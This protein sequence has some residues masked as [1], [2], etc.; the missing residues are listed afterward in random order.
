MQISST[1]AAGSGAAPRSP[2]QVLGKDQFLQLL[3]MQLQNQDPLQPVQDEQFLAQMAQFSA[4][5]QMNNIS[6]LTALHAGVQL[7]GHRV[8]AVDP[9]SGAPLTAIVTGVRSHGGQVLLR[10]GDQIEVPVDAV[11][12][13]SEK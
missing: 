2:S 5:E 9:G 4:L 7:L 1:G 13:V 3:V 11:T 6:S 8:S 12:Q 10:L